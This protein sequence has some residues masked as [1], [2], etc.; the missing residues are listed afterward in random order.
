MQQTFV[1]FLGVLGGLCQD[2]PSKGKVVDWAPHVAE[3]E[4]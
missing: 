4:P 3:K 2:F 1:E